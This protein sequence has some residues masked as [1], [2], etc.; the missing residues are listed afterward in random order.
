[1]LQETT[2]ATRNTPL[3]KAIEE[4]LRRRLDIIQKQ[5]ENNKEQ[6]MKSQPTFSAFQAPEYGS[7]NEQQYQGTREVE[8][9]LAQKV[10]A[11]FAAG[12]QLALTG[13]STSPRER[14]GKTRCGL[15]GFF[16]WERV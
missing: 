9:E 4:A 7:L 3:P 8:L 10:E 2:D 14:K 1:V 12:L 13:V 6:R 16:L 5:E 11:W 15:K